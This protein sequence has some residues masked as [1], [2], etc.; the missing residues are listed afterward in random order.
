MELNSIDDV[1]ALAEIQ[2]IAQIQRLE[3]KIRQFG[4]IPYFTL[5]ARLAHFNPRL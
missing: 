4:Y 3:K 1:N 5:V 2:K